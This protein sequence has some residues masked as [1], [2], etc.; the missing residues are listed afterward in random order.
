MLRVIGVNELILRER[1]T[2]EKYETVATET[3]RFYR[4]APSDRARP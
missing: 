4:V 2:D 3:A 1:D